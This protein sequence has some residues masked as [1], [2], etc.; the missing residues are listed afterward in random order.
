MLYPPGDPPDTG[1]E[2]QSPASPAL[3][4]GFFTTSAV[5]ETLI[6]YTLT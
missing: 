4:G 2:F 5:C 3:A 1:T 6:G